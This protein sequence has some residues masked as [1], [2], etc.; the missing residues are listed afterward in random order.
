[1]MLDSTVVCRRAL[2]CEWGGINKDKDGTHLARQESSG[3]SRA[4][5]RD[6]EAKA[7]KHASKCEHACARARVC[8]C[9]ARA[10]VCVCERVR[11]ARAQP[12]G[13][14]ARRG[15]RR[16]RERTPQP[17]VR[18]R[19]SRN[20]RPRPRRRPHRGRHPPRGTP[21]TSGGEHRRARRCSP[22]GGGGWKCRQAR[23]ASC[24]EAPHSRHSLAAAAVAVSRSSACTSVEHSRNAPNTCPRTRG[25]SC[26]R[27]RKMG[28]AAGSAM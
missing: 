13:D 23:A 3:T 25:N 9:D 15:P 18:R 16:G 1:M 19:Q 14:A 22:S 28:R 12:N 7:S 2:G 11:G 17:C 6:M 21:A 5:E 26:V 4:K 20:P 8:V 24:D 27:R 10:R